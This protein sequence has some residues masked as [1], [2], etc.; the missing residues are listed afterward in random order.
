[1]RIDPGTAIQRAL[2]F[3]VVKSQS[4]MRME[5]RNRSSDMSG[6]RSNLSS[7]QINR[8]AL[9]NTSYF[10]ISALAENLQK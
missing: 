8:G 9:K 5:H 1:M 3:I 10:S 4:A 6:Q 2:L 7:E